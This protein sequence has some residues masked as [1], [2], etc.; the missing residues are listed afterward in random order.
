MSDKPQSIVE[1]LSELRTRIVRSLIA[2]V[3][4]VGVSIAFADR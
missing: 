1:H 4:G 3:V 2:V